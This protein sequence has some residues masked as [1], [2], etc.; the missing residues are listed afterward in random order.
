MARIRV[1]LRI[2]AP[3][4]EVWERLRDIPSHVEWMADAERI[5]MTSDRS[6]GVGTAFECDT[7]VGRMRLTDHMEV[8]EW[9]PQRAFGVRHVGIVTG[10]GRFTLTETAGTTLL[11]WEEDLT[12][13]W[14]MG[15]AL[16]A[17][18]AAPVLRRIWR[19]NLARLRRLI[20]AP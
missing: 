9:E 13:P 2:G 7:R 6:E 12:F 4:A 17:R 1:E 10:T 18:L 14:W 16:G 20:E 5:R 11:A 19:G 15:S 3:A 8:T